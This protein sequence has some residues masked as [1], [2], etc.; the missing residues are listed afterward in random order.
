MYLDKFAVNILENV[1][2][3]L[4]DN[5]QMGIFWRIHLKM[6]VREGEVEK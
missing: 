3:V 2:I 5:P 4:T 1:E 6:K